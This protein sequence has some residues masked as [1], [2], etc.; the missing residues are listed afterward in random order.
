MFYVCFPLDLLEKSRVTFQLKAER[1]Y[2]IFYQITS[3]KKPELIGKRLPCRIISPTSLTALSNPSEFFL[4]FICYFIFR[5]FFAGLITLYLCSLHKHIRK[6]KK[7]IKMILPVS[8]T[9]IL[10][11]WKLGWISFLF[12]YMYLH[13]YKAYIIRSI[14]LKL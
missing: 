8:T 7:K 13:M 3:N 2:H 5:R 14:K 10:P 6:K 1:S 4:E 9:M 11:P 12:L